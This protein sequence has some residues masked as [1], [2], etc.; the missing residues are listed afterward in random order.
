MDIVKDIG[1]L[2]KVCRHAKKDD[3]LLEIASILQ[4]E[5]REHGGLGL[6]ANQVDIDIRMFVI[7]EHNQYLFLVNPYIVKQKGIQ[8]RMEGC[9]S[10]PGVFVKVKR[11]R[12]ITILGW[13]E[14]RKEVK[15][16]LSGLVACIACH[17]LDHLD[18]KL[19]IDKEENKNV[20]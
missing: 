1:F 13:N 19:I 7:K 5:V 4:S 12:E 18:G 15:Y 14:Q 17:E 8:K 11:P 16:K 10:L 3:D 9:L 20:T 2:R 6:A